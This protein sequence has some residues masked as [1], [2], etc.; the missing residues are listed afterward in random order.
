MN[1]N[2]IND[3]GVL[4]AIISRA[5][6]QGNIRGRL[7]ESLELRIIAAIHRIDVLEGVEAAKQ[8]AAECSVPSRLVQVKSSQEAEDQLDAI[9]S[10]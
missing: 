8:I 6:L 4:Q 1:I 9:F 3:A 7:S 10:K 2:E 5:I